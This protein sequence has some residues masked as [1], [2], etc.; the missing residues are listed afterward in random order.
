[1]DALQFLAEFGHI[2]N[3]PGGV[4]RLRE[5]ILQ[6]AITGRLI[7]REPDDVPASELIHENLAAQKRLVAH[8]RL[9]RLPPPQPVR[10][11]D[12][13]WQLPEGWSWTRLG[14]VTNYGDAP[15]VEY[16]NVDE[17]TWV[18]ELEDIE[19]G[20]SR[21]LNRVLAR[22]RTF[23]STK[24]GFPA[25]AVLYGKLR[26][27]LD[28]VLIADRSGVCTTEI[29]PISF[30]DGIEAAYLRWYL[31]SP[32]FIGYASASTHG[33]NLP[34]LGTDAAREALFPFPPGNEQASIVRK[35]NELMDLCAQLERQQHARRRLQNSLRQ[36][37]L[38]AVGKATN[39]YELQ[40]AW[41]RLAGNFGHLFSEPEDVAALRSMCV[42]LAI[43]GEL[44]T[45]G[46]AD[47][48]E[49][50]ETLVAS[51]R[52]SKR[53]RRVARIDEAHEPFP[54]PRNW[55]WVQ[56]EDL[57]ADSESGWSP[58]CDS[59]PRKPG[60]W[61]VLKV[62]AV[63]WGEFRPGE[64]K[65]L[66][67]S[68]RPRAECEARP[69]DFLLSRANTAEL[70]ARSVVVP[71][72]CPEK[73]LLSDKIVRLNFVDPSLKAWANL[74][75]N[76]GYARDYYRA[77]AT[78]TSDSMRNVSRQIIHELPFPLAPRDVQRSILRKVGQLHAWCDELESRLRHARE[79]AARFA[80]ASV[81]TFT[82]VNA[83]RHEDSPVKPPQT[84]LIAPLRLGEMP[85]VR[86][87]APLATMLARHDGEMSARELWQRYGGEIDAFY[88]QLKTE[89]GC[90]WILE[91][92]PAEVREL[93]A[94][95]EVA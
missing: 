54:L 40:A 77:N 60:E 18:L 67:P 79:L 2:A 80:A 84:E 70:V 34:R 78:G 16:P 46:D 51:L 7:D 12:A 39:P 95:A 5:L 76:S 74:V 68:L 10:S 26:P 62:S 48:G 86:S 88:A 33:M 71:E 57:L 41:N 45:G 87:R 36:P 89:V 30:F 91:P 38:A 20:S 17:D 55:A 43:R 61:G 58:K 49:S 37:A 19:K 4:G 50:I 81:A 94:A 66:P 65:R 56:F 11:T 29:V 83:L 28:K 8:K 53:G 72:R 47:Q 1:M 44:A 3:A 23:Q 31:K 14:A 90:R 13:L 82:G 75:N 63:T 93:A 42:E 73:L 21:L 27:Y 59:E 85:D 6:L 9:K 32:Y 52:E 92:E 25:G 35:V 69:G 15:K 64:N 22:E 24:N